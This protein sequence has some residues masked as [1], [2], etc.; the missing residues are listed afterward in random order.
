MTPTER[1]QA[2]LTVIAAK[3]EVA[4]AE[5]C[6]R[7]TQIAQQGHLSKRT[8]W[9]IF[10]AHDHYVSTLN[11]LADAMNYELVIELRKRA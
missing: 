4:R 9:A 1:Q 3:L 5:S 6:L 2:L 10:H 8:V 7:Q 11:E